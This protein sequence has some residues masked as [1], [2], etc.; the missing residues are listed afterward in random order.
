MKE[1]LDRS[2]AEVVALIRV[3]R[4]RAFR[5]ATKV[6]VELYWQVGQY[7]HSKVEA[8]SWG[9]GTVQNLADYIRRAIPGIRGFS[10][11]NLWRMRQFYGAYR[12]D[13]KLSPLVRE[14]PWT[15]NMIILS[16]CTRQEE[17]E[18]YLRLVQRE[19]W[20]KR[21]LEQEI[22][23]GLFERTVLSPANLSPA[24]REIHPCA[25]KV[26]RDVYVLDFLDLPEPHSENEL[27]RGLVRDI[28]QFLQT[29]GADFC[30]IGEEY[31]I[32]VGGKDFYLDLL[33]FHRGLQ[34]L[35]LF[36]LKID[37]FKPEYLGKLEF[38]LEALDRDIRKPDEK[39]SVGVL[40]CK[41]KDSEVVEYALSRSL[42]PAVVAQYQTQLPDKA[43]LQQ[44]LHEFYEL[45]ASRASE[46]GEQPTP[47]E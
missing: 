10:A 29:L 42:S 2:F 33:F 36:E 31:R 14:L 41:S 44:K 30:F 8:E 11:Q 17:R 40:L 4:G 32:Q 23:G 24:V 45:E 1:S 47:H 13:E 43:L 35:V 7:V 21:H 37:D 5:A 16:K 20:D 18:F 34:C 26:F 28:R 27:Q 38:Y 46:N 6:T 39:P 3:A 19:T 12:D 22:D 25:S 15:H 9:K